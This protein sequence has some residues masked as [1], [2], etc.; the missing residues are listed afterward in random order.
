MYSVGRGIEEECMEYL[1][2]DQATSLWLKGH[3]KHLV[4]NSTSVFG[5]HTAMTDDGLLQPGSLKGA[6]RL[7]GRSEVLEKWNNAD[8]PYDAEDA[9]SIC[10]NFS[11]SQN[12][13]S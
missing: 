13:N 12:P 5:H 7:Y 10:T 6:A 1:E 8:K 2:L 11:P 4:I 3:L 9:Q